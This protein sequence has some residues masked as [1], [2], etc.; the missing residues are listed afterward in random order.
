MR[1]GR[2]WWMISGQ[3]WVTCQASW[4]P[5]NSPPPPLPI[6]RL[7]KMETYAEILVTV[8]ITAL[9][10]PFLSSNCRPPLSRPLNCLRALKHLFQLALPSGLCDFTFSLCHLH[11]TLNQNPLWLTERTGKNK[12]R[13][14]KVRNKSVASRFRSRHTALYEMEMWQDHYSVCAHLCDFC[15]CV[16]TSFGV[17]VLDNAG[18]IEIFACECLCL[19]D[20]R[21]A[22]QCMNRQSKETKSEK[23]KKKKQQEEKN[24]DVYS[25][26]LSSLAIFSR[27]RRRASPF[28]LDSGI[29]NYCYPSL[30]AQKK[31][32]VT[33]WCST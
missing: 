21:G 28:S 8:G 11:I 20:C 5:H 25:V 12:T 29:I 9:L 3:L 6:I 30:Y 22:T 33:D 16:C 14:K 4:P 18:T 23:K 26:Y 31:Q 1:R 24:G 13:K 10:R 19:S 7:D 2:E 27:K 32:H 15:V 17:S